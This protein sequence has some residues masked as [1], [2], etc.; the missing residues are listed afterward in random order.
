MKVSSC[1]LEDGLFALPPMVNWHL[2][3]FP[4]LASFFLLVVFPVILLSSFY[5]SFSGLC[6][7]L[8]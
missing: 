3:S 4:L 6:L 1:G 5:F 7:V 8:E 2:L